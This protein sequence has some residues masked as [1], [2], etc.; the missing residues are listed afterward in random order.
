MTPLERW[1]W[2]YCQSASGPATAV[3]TCLAFHHN[4]R[5]GRCD[6]SLSTISEETGYSQR[7]VR[8]SLNELD[9]LGLVIRNYRTGKSAEYSLQFGDE[10]APTADRSSEDMVSADRSSEDTLSKTPDRSSPKRVEREERST[11]PTPPCAAAPKRGPR[12]GLPMTPTAQPAAPFTYKGSTPFPSPEEQEENKRRVRAEKTAAD[13][14]QRAEDLETVR[15]I[16][17]REGTG[18]AAE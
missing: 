12:S 4:A 13:E 8:R 6:P 5:T 9:R 17:E 10:D 15:R 2:S 16:R 7:H 11:A 18:H 14:R 3:L 1:Q